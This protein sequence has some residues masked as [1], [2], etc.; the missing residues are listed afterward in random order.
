MI[1]LLVVT[2]RK[3]EGRISLKV[4]CITSLLS[5]IFVQVPIVGIHVQFVNSMMY[6]QIS[7]FLSFVYS[8]DVVCIKII[9]IIPYN[10]KGVCVINYTC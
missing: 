2:S 6:Q 4:P 8:Y 3:N 10:I 1:I 7:Y 5:L 9:T